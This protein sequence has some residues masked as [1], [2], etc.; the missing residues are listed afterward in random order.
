MRYYDPERIHGYCR[1]CDKYSLFWPCPPFDESP[2]EKL[3]AWSRAVL[4]TQKTWV[5][6]GSTKESLVDQFLVARQ[7]LGDALKK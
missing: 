7:I 3:P 5:D 2:L 6:P 4:I 1:S